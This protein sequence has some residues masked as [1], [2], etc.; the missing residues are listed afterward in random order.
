MLESTAMNRG[1][2][3]NSFRNKM[4]VKEHGLK[5]SQEWII[6][7][8]IGANVSATLFIPVC[9]KAWKLNTSTAVPVMPDIASQL[10]IAVLS[11][12]SEYLLRQRG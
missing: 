2:I 7:D 4:T 8:P 9:W 12:L 10:H 5:L 1:K 3:G 6:D 11:I